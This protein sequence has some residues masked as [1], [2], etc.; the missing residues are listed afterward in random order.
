MHYIEISIHSLKA[1]DLAPQRKC[2]QPVS[3]ASANS[4]GRGGGRGGRGAGGGGGAHGEWGA[5]RY[6]TTYIWHK[7]ESRHFSQFAVS[8]RG[9]N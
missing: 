1:P 3:S 4:R 5:I 6:T 8:G 2:T 9:T 7:F